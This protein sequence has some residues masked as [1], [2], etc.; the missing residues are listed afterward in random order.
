[1]KISFDY[2]VALSFSGHDRK[3]AERLANELTTK[4][5]RVF[6]DAYE[7]GSLW[8]EDLYTYLADIYSKKAQYCV[9]FLSQHYSSSLWTSHERR[10]AQARAFREHSAYILPLKLDDT[11]IPGIASTT[12]YV[13][14]RNTTIEEVVLLVESKLS[15]SRSPIADDVPIWQRML[16]AYSENVQ[17]QANKDLGVQF[18]IPLRYEIQNSQGFAEEA[19]RHWLSIP[20]D[21]L[22]VILGDYGTG[23]TT[24]CL[25]LA[26]ILCEEITLNN[27]SAL[28]PIYVPLR[29][30]SRFFRMPDPANAL[31]EYHGVPGKIGASKTYLLMFD[32]YDELL[33]SSDRSLFHTTL[34]N[35]SVKSNVKILMTARSHFFRTQSEAL[36]KL[37]SETRRDS[38]LTSVID[39][40]AWLLDRTMNLL[41]LT[42]SD[43][44]T[45]LSLRFE[46][47]ISVYF[48][49]L[50]SIYDLSDLAKRPI[51]L[52]LIAKALPEIDEQ[53]VITQDKLYEITVQAWLKRE[54]WRGLNTD[55]MM[56]FME[57][58]ATTM[59]FNEVLSIH[60]SDLSNEIR[61]SFFEEILSR[62]DIEYFDNLIRTS[63]F[64]FRD[65]EGNFSFMHRSFLEYFF[66]RV[67]Q[68]RINDDFL[69][70][71]SDTELGEDALYNFSQFWLDPDESNQKKHQVI[72]SVSAKLNRI[73]DQ[74]Y[75]LSDG[76]VEL[77]VSAL[78]HK[79]SGHI[80]TE[81]ISQFASKREQFREDE[82]TLHRQAEKIRGFGDSEDNSDTNIERAFRRVMMI[83][84]QGRI[85]YTVEHYSFS[86]YVNSK[87]PHQ[88][89]VLAL[90]YDESWIHT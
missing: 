80:V 59:F 7:T 74:S 87:E 84:G 62:M 19:I 12:G 26:K 79:Y 68:K 40:A 42:P 8:G 27:E 29:D 58:L 86:L 14:L 39:E 28:I 56:I 45:Y 36:S 5:I 16:M 72:E 82:R 20:N 54:T 81:R 61:E 44:R 50:I 6:Y 51:L 10:F 64:L 70:L 73:Y 9:M 83:G 11:E 4:G 60:Y 21:P 67:L 35:L 22:R 48:N 23:K 2:D 15:S 32:G 66:G 78:N 57:N 90:G 1:M 49:K 13:D 55:A 33:D 63:G 85:Y 17:V 38:S 47:D 34:R 31:L 43:I 18:Y 89:W 30:T 65:T 53:D 52:S 71:A 25:H 24:L 46:G 77:L 41:E 88:P 75:S 37:A 3:H 69:I 76:I